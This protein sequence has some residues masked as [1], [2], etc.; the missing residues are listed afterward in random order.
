MSQ[1]VPPP[2]PAHT[3]RSTPARPAHGLTGAAWNRR[4]VGRGVLGLAHWPR[5]LR[6]IPDD[7]RGAALLHVF[8]AL[9]FALPGSLL[10][11]S[12]SQ[13]ASLPL[14][15]A[16]LLF[17]AVH[18][19]LHALCALHHGRHGAA[20][21]LLAA[22]DR[23]L[24]C[25]LL[26]GLLIPLAAHAGGY[27]AFGLLALGWLA[28]IAVLLSS[29]RAWP[30]YP[31]ARRALQSAATGIVLV[32]TTLLCLPLPGQPLAWLLGSGLALALAAVVALRRHRRSRDGLRHALLVLGSLLQ[33][34]VV[35]LITVP[36]SG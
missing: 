23:H 12:G 3:A 14:S 19:G 10:A 29:A 15:S 16:V 13:R 6:A 36:A 21:P 26:V 5:W 9:F 34:I 24:P 32:C 8:A 1:G 2:R 33:F 11:L 4:P 17:V 18:A 35:A 30:R 7:E 28:A 27:S 20:Q 25:L 22:L 31:P